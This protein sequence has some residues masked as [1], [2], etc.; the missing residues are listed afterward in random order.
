MIT[1]PELRESTCKSCLVQELAG[2][3][4]TWHYTKS[5]SESSAKAAGLYTFFSFPTTAIAYHVV[6]QSGNM[7][8]GL[9]TCN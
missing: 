2:P 9:C 5:S 4:G 3:D 1:L 7:C 8:N 6:W